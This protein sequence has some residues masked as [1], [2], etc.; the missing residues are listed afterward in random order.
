MVVAPSSVRISV[1]DSKDILM[2]PSQVYNRSQA[3][4]HSQ[5]DHYLQVT[6]YQT[7]PIVR[8]HHSKILGEIFILQSRSCN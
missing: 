5:I 6:T 1:F 2:R 4:R 8:L 3:Y 7:K